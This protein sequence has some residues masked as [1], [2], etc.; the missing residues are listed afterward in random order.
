MHCQNIRNLNKM[1]GVNNRMLL[2]KFQSE[3]NVVKKFYKQVLKLAKNTKIKEFN[4]SSKIEVLSYVQSIYTLVWL[5][6]AANDNSKDSM[7]KAGFIA[8]M[9]MEKYFGD[10][11]VYEGF[12]EEFELLVRELAALNPGITVPE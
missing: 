1:R 9:R 3:R 11:P 10:D 4:S 7:Q 5:G 12:Y 2:R 6:I 8:S